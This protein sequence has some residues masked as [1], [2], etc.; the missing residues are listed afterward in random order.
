MS[1]VMQ[2]GCNAILKCRE[3]R[4]LAVAMALHSRL[5]KDSSLALLPKDLFKHCMT[6]DD[7]IHCTVLVNG[8]KV[9]VLDLHRISKVELGEGIMGTPYTILKVGRYD[10]GTLVLRGAVEGLE[11]IHRC[12]DQK[13]T[14]RSLE[15]PNPDKYGEGVLHVITQKVWLWPCWPSTDVYL[16]HT[17]GAPNLPPVHKIVLAVDLPAVLAEH[18]VSSSD[19][20]DEA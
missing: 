5:G 15:T 10:T 3:E 2:V 4:N 11:C 17:E 8:V 16:L 20:E 9:N 7:T 14:D 19:R 12:S 1:M 13:I 18:E 6:P